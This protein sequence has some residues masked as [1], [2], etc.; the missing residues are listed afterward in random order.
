MSRHF[1]LLLISWSLLAFCWWGIA[2]WLVSRERH[3]PPLRKKR[4]SDTTQP[5]QP[6]LSIFKPIPALQ[7]DSPSP[8][9]VGALE[10]FVSQLTVD[11]EMLLGIDSQ[12]T[13]KRLQ[14]A[15]QLRRR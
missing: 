10:S 4:V 12:L 3:K 5:D 7:G 1:E 2:L 8:Q 14:S 15:D 13:D 11:A 6:P 9:L